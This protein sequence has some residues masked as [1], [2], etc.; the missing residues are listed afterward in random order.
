[1][2]IRE[3]HA[4]FLRGAEAGARTLVG[5]L[6]KGAAEGKIGPRDLAIVTGVMTDKA[7]KLA[8]LAAKDD[9]YVLTDEE[10]ADAE[11]FLRRQ[12]LQ[13]AQAHGRTTV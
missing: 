9:P 12:E 7:V 11:E 8:P 10:R 5:I 2:T 13:T 3:L 6:E 4:V 1:M